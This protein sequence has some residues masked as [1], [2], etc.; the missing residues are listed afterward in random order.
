MGT[1]KMFPKAI[2]PA[3]DK[4]LGMKIDGCKADKANLDQKMFEFHVDKIFN[5]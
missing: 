1:I 5:C 2:I 3:I 4:F